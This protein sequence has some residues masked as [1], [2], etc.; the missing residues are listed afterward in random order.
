MT[1]EKL[2]TETKRYGDQYP[3]SRPGPMTYLTAAV[4]ITG[5]AAMVYWPAISSFLNLVQI[6]TNLGL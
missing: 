1:K 2:T 3:P 5:I 6:R 4:V